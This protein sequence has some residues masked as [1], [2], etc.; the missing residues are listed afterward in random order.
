MSVKLH[1]PFYT[2]K[3]LLKLFE[4]I[5]NYDLD[6]VHVSNFHAKNN[7]DLYKKIGEYIFSK[8]KDTNIIIIGETNTLE[9]PIPPKSKLLLTSSKVSKTNQK[10]YKKVN[11]IPTSEKQIINNIE[12]RIVESFSHT[13]GFENKVGEMMLF[14]ILKLW[15]LTNN[16]Q[17]IKFEVYDVI[18]EALGTRDP[19]EI[20]EIK[21][22]D[23]VSINNINK[24]S[25]HY[26]RIKKADLNKPILMT[27]YNKKPYLVDG[28]HRLIKAYI[29]KE[30]YI[31]VRMIP[32]DILLKTQV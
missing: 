4:L 31:P 16:I 30:E 9:L 3:I 19:D 28:W 1:L 26:K 25:N 20:D 5:N 32:R 7:A 11:Y 14:D 24:N 6:I 13:G 27:I 23:D 12:S 15:Y 17:S 21:L 2:E 10:K 8:P 18:N 29:L 22:W